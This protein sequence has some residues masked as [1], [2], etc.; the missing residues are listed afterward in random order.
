MARNDRLST[1]RESIPLWP[2]LGCP[3][4]ST[5]PQLILARLL[6]RLTDATMSIPTNGFNAGSTIIA[7]RQEPDMRANI[8]ERRQADGAGRNRAEQLTLIHS[9]ATRQLRRVSHSMFQK[10]PLA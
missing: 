1:L 7:P 8:C 10:T 5:L 4:P 9:P 3:A 6:S 2:T